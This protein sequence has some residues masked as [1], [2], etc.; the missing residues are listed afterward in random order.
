ML[1]DTYDFILTPHSQFLEYL[2]EAMSNSC[3]GESGSGWSR[4]DSGYMFFSLYINYL[5][6]VDLFEVLVGR[7]IFSAITPVQGPYKTERL[8]HPLPLFM[9]AGTL[10]N[11]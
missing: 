2:L 9:A 6:I 7:D 10:P 8:C 11:M 5:T 1:G 3:L 4:R